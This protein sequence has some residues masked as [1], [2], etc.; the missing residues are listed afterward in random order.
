MSCPWTSLS[1]NVTRPPTATSTSLGLAPLAVIVIVAVGGGGTGTEGAGDTA[2]GA[3]GAPGV[4][5]ISPHP[6]ITP[7]VASSMDNVDRGRRCIRFHKGRAVDEPRRRLPPGHSRARHAYRDRKFL[8]L[9]KHP[10]AICAVLIAL[11][12]ASNLYAQAP[13]SDVSSS[14]SGWRW[15]TSAV[16]FFGL[17]Y[18]RRKFTDFRKWESQ[19]WLMAMGDRR[20]NSGTLTITS[21]FSLEPF[22][23]QKLGSPQVFQGGETYHGGPLID[24]QHPHDLL[25]ELSAGFEHEIGPVAARFSASLAG[26]AA[27][28]P[29]VF[30]H[31]QSAVDNPQVPLAHHYMDSTH[32]SNGV[33]SAGAAA[34]QVSLDGSWFRGREPD[35]NRTDIDI[36]ALDSWSVR[37]IWAHGPWSAQLSGGHL[38]KPEVLEPYDQTRV[39]ASVSYSWQGAV[40]SV[41]TL[42]AWGENREIHGNLDAYLSETH[43]RL[44]TRDAIY[45]RA[46]LV[47]KDVLNKGGLHPIGFFHPHPISRVAAFTAGYVRDFSVTSYGR[48]GLGGD[49]TTY[50]V[51]RNLL[52]SYG[53]PVSFHLFVRFRSIPRAAMGH[54]HAQ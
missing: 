21:M 8:R 5:L 41:D 26:P 7:A 45:S 3:L 4:E 46:E 17:N 19:N 47:A 31:R 32:I 44:T 27:L 15:T 25:M 33:I 52:D 9:E 48:A 11:L 53:S 35:D 20:L 37:G 24:Y 30:M 14:E 18:Q 12:H 13:P 51:A 28:G 10:H 23:M 6:A 36:G 34:G 16:A 43:A 42:I 49:V 22:T 50:R 39:T 2:G 40:R 29:P 54:A 38:S 1:G